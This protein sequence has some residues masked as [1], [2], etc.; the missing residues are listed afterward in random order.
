[1]V[2]KE[3]QVTVHFTAKDRD[4]W[5]KMMQYRN[6]KE[7][8]TQNYKIQEA[9]QQQK[10]DAAH[11]QERSNVLITDQ[12]NSTDVVKP[13]RK[14]T[15]R[16]MPTT[17]TTDST[18]STIEP[19]PVATEETKT[20]TP[21]KKQASTAKKHTNVNYVDGRTVR[22]R[23]SI[24]DSTDALYHPETATLA[25]HP[26]GFFKAENLKKQPDQLQKV[27][28]V[29]AIDPGHAKIV[30]CG[31]LQGNVNE[32]LQTSISVTLST[33]GGVSAVA[34]PTDEIQVTQDNMS[35]IA[36]D[37]NV[38][39]PQ[40]S[41]VSSPSSPSLVSTCSTESVNGTTPVISSPLKPVHTNNDD[42]KCTVD[43]L[44]RGPRQWKKLT[45]LSK[46]YYYKAIGN[47]RHTQDQA[48]KKDVYRKLDQIDAARALQKSQPGSAASS[49]TDTASN[50]SAET[51]DTASVAT[52]PRTGPS[53]KSSY[54]VAAME[55]TLD[56]A[57]RVI[58]NEREL[59]DN[60][61]KTHVAEDIM[62]HVNIWI[63]G[64]AARDA[65]YY[66][67][68]Q[69]RA[70]FKRDQMKEQFYQQFLNV[71][72]PLKERDSTVLFVGDAEF[73]TSF[74]GS[75]A[76]P[77]R[78]LIKFLARHIRVVLVDEFHTTK[79]CYMC[80]NPD[81]QAYNEQVKAST[82][83]ELLKK[84]Q[85]ASN[86]GAAPAATTTKST[87][88][89][90]DYTTQYPDSICFHP[91]SQFHYTEL[92]KKRQAQ[93]QKKFPHVTDAELQ[94]KYKQYAS[95]PI[96][97]L[98]RC[99]CCTR[100]YNRDH[101]AFKAIGN[102]GLDIL[103][104]G[105]PQ[106]PFDKTLYT[107]QA[108][109]VKKNRVATVKVSTTP[110]QTNAKRKNAATPIVEDLSDNQQQANNNSINTTHDPPCKRQKKTTS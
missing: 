62:Q 33:R 56:T 64:F 83:K 7:T 28:R 103:L 102:K 94:A 44:P 99:R 75:Q 66:S 15:R 36:A 46:N 34:A 78:A 109:T 3:I 32:L 52:M 8:R 13:K 45:D 9:A 39:A 60:S 67:N 14:Y 17:T 97:G 88:V 81:A 95:Y 70:S 49:Q 79:M 77:V 82:E 90:I 71:I 104:T 29:V 89:Q 50:V 10:E 68:N 101:N 1:M 59:Q 53:S 27:T 12:A 87:L 42:L 16:K 4:R 110:K 85:Q 35:D 106:V 43:I 73:A 96:H 98:R 69:S 31:I 5:E 108:K 26:H 21:R 47:R 57:I 92:P 23:L 100:Y 18:T 61:I 40:T 107:A 24:Y 63:D 72:A 11:N 37:G 6:D 80:T 91:M 84:T 25:D 22:T 76:T 19:Q 93:L 74:R 105:N 58:V 30:S 51:G 20:N 38:Y 65:F 55:K 48:K 54:S 41:F 86:E 2:Q